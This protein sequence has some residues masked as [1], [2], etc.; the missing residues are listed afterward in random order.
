MKRASLWMQVRIWLAERI[1]GHNPKTTMCEDSYVC[2]IH[3]RE[4]VRW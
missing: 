2:C 1:M 3:R 4:W